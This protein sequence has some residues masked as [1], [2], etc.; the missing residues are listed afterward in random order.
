MGTGADIRVGGNCIFGV[1]LTGAACEMGMAVAT[2]DF[3]C[4]CCFL[5][6]F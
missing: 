4:S 5:C 1:D 6:V 3:I 2:P